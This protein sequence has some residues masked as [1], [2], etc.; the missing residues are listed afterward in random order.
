[1]GKCGVSFGLGNIQKIEDDEPFGGRGP[2]DQDFDALSEP[3]APQA[4]AA[5]PVNDPLF[6]PGNGML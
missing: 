5:A 4:A 3:M 2:A 6:G 1:M